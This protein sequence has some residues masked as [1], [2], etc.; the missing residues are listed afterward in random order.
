[1]SF[2]DLDELQGEHNRLKDKPN[3]GNYLDNFV[4][5][6][7]GAGHVTLRLLPPA[8]SGAFGRAKNP[9]FMSTRTHR[10]NEKSIHCPN[11]MVNGKWVGNCPICK[12][13]RDLWAQSESKAPAEAKKLQDAYRDLKAIDRY[14]YNVIVRQQMNEQTNEIEKNVGPKILSVGKTVHKMIIRA[15]VG[16]AEMDEPA[17]GDVTDPVNGRDFKLIKTIRGANGYPNYDTSKFLDVAPLGNPEE[18]ERWLSSLHD[19]Y[20]LRI[21]KSIEEIES[22]L[23]VHLG[24]KRDDSTEFSATD[25]EVDVE[26]TPAPKV[27]SRTTPTV[28]NS[29]PI[30]ES[31]FLKQLRGITT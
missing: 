20:S 28:D 10:I 5:M 13:C 18:V 4:I 17:L 14:Y 19:L 1:M 9:F 12:H 16:D 31:E 15:I 23:S 27:E 3:Q 24:L 30:V 29:K 11:E 21:V 8:K 6:P 26:D 2:L 22:E 25:V 7:K